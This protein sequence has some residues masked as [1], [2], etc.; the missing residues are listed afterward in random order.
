MR[1]G[2]WIVIRISDGQVICE[3]FNKKTVNKINKQKYR[4]ETI[5]EYLVRLNS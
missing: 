4:I 5:H 1:A 3:I 2:S